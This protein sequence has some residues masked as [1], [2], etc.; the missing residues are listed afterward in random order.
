MSGK[1]AVAE[2]EDVAGVAAVVGEH[3]AH[4]RRDDVP[5]REAHRG[6]EV[7]LQ[8]AA[9]PPVRARA[10]DSGVRQSTP[11]TSA[12]AA[13]NSAEQLAGV[14]AEVDARHVEVRERGEHLRGRGQHEPLVVRRG[15][16]APAQLSNSC[17]ARAPCSICDRNDAI[18]RSARRSSSAC[19]QRGIA[20]HERLRLRVRA[21]RPALDEIGRDRERRAREADERDV[22]GQLRADLRDGLEHVRRVAFGVERTKAIEIGASIGT[23]RATTGPVPGAMS[24]PKPMAATGT[25]MSE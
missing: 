4:F 21:R 20:V 3:G 2:V 16:S 12:P 23:V 14:D 5:R 15:S 9:R 24:T 8:R 7:A 19:P 17:T 1:H 6:V 11:T 22:V 25:T 18:A 10:A 13:A